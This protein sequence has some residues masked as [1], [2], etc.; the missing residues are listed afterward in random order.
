MVLSDDHCHAPEM[1]LCYLIGT[2]S[3]GIHN[4]W[5]PVVL[6]G[7]SGSNWISNVDVLYATSGYVNTH[8]CGTVS[9]RTCKKT[10]LLGSTLVGELTALEVETAEAEWVCETLMDLP[11]VDKHVSAILMNCDNQTVTAKANNSKDNVKSSRRVK[12]RL[13]SI[14]KLRNSGVIIV[15]YIPTD[16]NLPDAF[17]NRLSRM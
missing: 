9:W 8:G 1:V 7:Y 16:K 6:E 13:K 2:M 5:H 11:V 14:R 17:T 12:L 3:Y 15:T 4:S 10:I